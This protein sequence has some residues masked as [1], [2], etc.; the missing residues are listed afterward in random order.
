MK[1]LHE[2]D[3]RSKA[4]MLI[5][6]NIMNKA[7]TEYRKKLQNL[8]P[9]HIFTQWH[10]TSSGNSRCCCNE[11]TSTAGRNQDYLFKRCF[12]KALSCYIRPRHLTQSSLHSIPL[13][14]CY[15]CVHFTQHTLVWIA[16]V[17]AEKQLC[18]F[19]Y[20]VGKIYH[21]FILPLMTFPYSNICYCSDAG[22]L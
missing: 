8:T 19:Q 17:L 6:I 4:Y 12:Q 22:L 1:L 21:D 9:Q 5:N 3:K 18:W 13:H 11:T 2:A 10:R 20:S 7:V 14:T 15:K 16:C